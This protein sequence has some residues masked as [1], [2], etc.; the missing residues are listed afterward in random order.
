MAAPETLAAFA[1]AQ[2][3]AWKSGRKTLPPAQTAT[4]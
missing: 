1:N 3:Q 4:S 2:E